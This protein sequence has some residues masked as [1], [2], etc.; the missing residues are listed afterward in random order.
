[1]ERVKLVFFSMPFGTKPVGEQEK[2][3]IDATWQKLLKPAVPEGWDS[4][5]IDEVDEPGAI[6]D[7]FKEFLRSADVVVFDVTSAN[8]NVLYE[9]GIRDVFAPGRRVLVARAGTTPPFNIAAERVLPYAPDVATAVADGFPERLRLQILQVAGDVAR[10]SQSAP[11]DSRLRSQLERAANVPSLV[12][13]WQ[14]WKT[15]KWIPVDRL[16]QLATLFS[17][18]RRIDLAIEVT[19]RAYRESPAEWEVARLLGWYLRKSGAHEEAGDL[20]RQALALNPSDVESMGMLGGLYKRK[21]MDLMVNGD[22]DGARAWFCQSRDM[23]AGAHAVE[24]NEN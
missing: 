23:Y 19:R 5:R 10:G 18:H 2:H 9:L 3:D 7:Q 21:A 24:K 22:L 14:E 8:P 16:L 20:L 15:F 12:A 13:L 6:P 1:M 4:K 11:D 17:Q